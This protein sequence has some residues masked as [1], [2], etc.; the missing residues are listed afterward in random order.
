VLQDLLMA[1]R[2]RRPQWRGE[3]RPVMVRVP[4]PVAEA[5]ENLAA[6]KGVSLSDAAGC[7]IST[8][9]AQQSGYGFMDSASHP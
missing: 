9:L 4:V 2:R 5:L 6:A 7:L 1:T 3:R 8:G